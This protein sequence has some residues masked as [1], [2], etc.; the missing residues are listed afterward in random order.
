MV[1]DPRDKLLIME[2]LAL[3]MHFGLFEGRVANFITNA[4]LWLSAEKTDKTFDGV[5]HVFVQVY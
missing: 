4:V 1:K 3:I 5:K 2:R